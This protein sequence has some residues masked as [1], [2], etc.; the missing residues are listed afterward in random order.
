MKITASHTVRQLTE[1]EN[2]DL[3]IKQEKELFMENC[4]NLFGNKLSYGNNK[5]MIV[6]D[7]D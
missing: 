7:A 2:C 1:K 4:F 6:S 3:N 5:P